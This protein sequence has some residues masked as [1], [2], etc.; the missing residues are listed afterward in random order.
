VGYE[1]SDLEALQV[2]IDAEQCDLL[3]VLSYIS[4]LTPP[5]TR[6][7]RVDQSREKIFEG[8]DSEDKEFLDFVLSKYQEKGVEELGEEKLPVLLNLKYH[9]IA[10]AEQSLGSV[11]DIRSTFFSFQ[12]NLYA[13]QEKVLS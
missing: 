9:A 3:D 5:I 7:Q 12:K 4:F 6:A 2:M 11:E 13:K 1:K 8:L 10:N